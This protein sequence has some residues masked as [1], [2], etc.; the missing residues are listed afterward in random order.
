ML[1]SESPT[2]STQENL[3]QQ[4]YNLLSPEQ[5]ACIK[6]Y[7]MQYLAPFEGPNPP[8]LLSSASDHA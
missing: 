7:L 2:G 8:F 3:A 6:S 4:A 5:K 1:A